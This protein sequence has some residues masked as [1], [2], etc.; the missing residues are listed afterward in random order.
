MPSTELRKAVISIL[1]GAAV[2]A[3][4]NILQGVLNLILDYKDSLIP[5][6]TAGISYFRMNRVV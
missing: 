3:L 2:M 4:A 6:T 5:A 1:I